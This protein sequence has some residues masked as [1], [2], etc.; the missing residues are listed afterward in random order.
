VDKTQA[1][2]IEAHF[3]GD[4]TI[5]AA[6]LAGGFWGVEAQT[7]YLDEYGE[8]IYLEFGSDDDGSVLAQPLTLRGG[9]LTDDYIVTELDADDH[10]AV[11]EAIRGYLKMDIPTLLSLA[12]P[13]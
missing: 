11:A 7:D 3:E 5:F 12:K 13:Y 1:E 10:E 9:Q 8:I 2:A 6:D 4:P